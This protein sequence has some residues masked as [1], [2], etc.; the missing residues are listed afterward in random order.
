MT[1]SRRN[2]LLVGLFVSVALLLIVATVLAVGGASWFS[3][4][5]PASVYFQGSVR[6]LY[7]GAPVTFRGVKVG[8]VESIG[9]EIDSKTL[10]A[11]IPVRLSLSAG[12]VRWGD[13]Q[14]TSVQDLPELVK[15]GLRAR[16]AMQSVV[17]GQMGVDLDFMPDTPLA[18]AN[19]RAPDPEIPAIKDRL[20]ALI[21]QVSDLPVRELALDLRRTLQTLDQTLK[22]T[23]VA[24]E[25]T[26]R[27]L[28]STGAE[29]RRT[30]QTA[31]QA[32]EDV[33]TQSHATLV[34]VQRLSDA[35][36]QTVQQ[37]QPELQRTLEAARDSAAQARQAMQ[38][39]AELTAPGAPVRADLDA[40]LRDLA[41]A[42]RSLRAF[43]EQLERQP[44]ALLFGKPAP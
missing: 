21:E 27:E 40:A 36:R 41:L 35:S 12:A 20:D 1:P 2:A 9:I 43:G 26:G 10:A 25:R 22:A 33:Q 8:E 23:Q 16:L 44:N 14:A 11:R 13:Q 42:T 15:R 38:Q 24:M 4:R 28:G 32:L 6:G 7:V 5:I 30:L 29:A 18:F 19:P 31:T 39:V 3:S 37:A 17:T 34:S